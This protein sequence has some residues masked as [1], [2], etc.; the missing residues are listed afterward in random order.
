MNE[1]LLKNLVAHEDSSSSA[2][3]E[4]WPSI[5]YLFHVDQKT[6]CTASIIGSRWML[7]SFG[8]VEKL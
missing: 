8:C 1:N 4:Q 3:E 5:A 7:A 6:S 2:G